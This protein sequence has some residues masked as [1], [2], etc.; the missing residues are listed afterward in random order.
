MHGITAVMP[1]SSIVNGGIGVGGAI[2]LG[3]MGFLDPIAAIAVSVFII[4]AAYSLI[5]KSMNELMEVSLSEDVENEIVQI[6][7]SCSK[8]REIH[9]L[10][11][12]HIGSQVS[13]EMHVRM[14]GDIPLYEAHVHVSEI[15]EKLR[16]RFG[17]HTYINIH[18]E[19]VKVKGV[20]QAPDN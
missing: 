7:E 19:P 10:R 2:L 16:K 13:I 12:R 6:A 18:D 14:P 15:E 11:T 3:H 20:Y 8:V 9:N 17:E 1:F 4:R 5:K